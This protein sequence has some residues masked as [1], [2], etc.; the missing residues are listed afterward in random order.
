M[1][2][3]LEEQIK[4]YLQEIIEF[5]E[6]SQTPDLYKFI[7]AHFYYEYIHPFYDGNGR[8]GSLLISSYEARKLDKFTAII[9]SHLHNKGGGDILYAKLT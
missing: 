4:W 6:H 8:T 7:L 3:F 5:L 2:V 9:L 1:G